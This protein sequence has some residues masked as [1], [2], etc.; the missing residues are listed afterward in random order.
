[1]PRVE[2]VTIAMLLFF[3][4]FAALLIWAFSSRSVLRLWLWMGGSGA[5]LSAF[6][7]FATSQGGP[8]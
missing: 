7:A 8:A 2:A 5:V 4:L 6:L 3:A 1:V